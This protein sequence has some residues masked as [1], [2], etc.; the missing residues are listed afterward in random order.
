MKKTALYFAIFWSVS[1][2]CFGHIDADDLMKTQYIGID[3]R[4]YLCTNN[5]FYLQCL[6]IFSE[7]NP[8]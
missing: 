6:P 7:M 8:K 3:N 1:N 2:I 4:S 5:F